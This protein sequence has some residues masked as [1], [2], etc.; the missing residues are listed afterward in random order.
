MDPTGNRPITQDIDSV[1]EDTLVFF[2]PGTYL[3]DRIW[4]IRAKKFGDVGAGYKKKKPPTGKQAAVFKSA[5]GTHAGVDYRATTALFGSFIFDQTANNSTMQLKARSE[6]FCQSRDVVWSGVIDTVGSPALDQH[7]YM[8]YLQ[9]MNEDA[10]SRAA[11]FSMVHNGIPGTKNI[12]AKSGVWV[13]SENV[14]TAQIE[15]CTVIGNATNAIY[16]G[17][18]PGN[19]Q[20]KDGFYR[21]NEVSQNRFSGKGS[22]S[23]GITIE[24]DS[25][26]Y[27]GPV[28]EYGD[29]GERIATSGIQIERGDNG[30]T[31]PSGAIIRN[32]DIR[33][34]SVGPKGM[35]AGI[36]VLGSGG[37]TK[38]GNSRIVTTISERSISSERP[39][40]GYDGYTAPPP[41][42][43]T[44][45]DS[46][47]MGTNASKA[48][49]SGVRT[50]MFGVRVSKFRVLVPKA[51]TARISEKTSGSG[52]PVKPAVSA[53]QRKSEVANHFPQYLS[54]TV[55]GAV[56]GHPIRGT[57][58]RKSLP[59]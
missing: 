13:G 46:L 51:S 57:G 5:A 9:S 24:I 20:I 56:R 47:L 14:G 1:P 33:I 35:C 18:T 39:G 26:N 38:I 19:T 48:M 37:A 52:K 42:N 53:L 7:D 50:H 6:G 15:D 45:I 2:P 27:S 58:F 31:K 43:I 32:A 25:D 28:G 34:R 22:W 40:G 3:L 10:V 8:C 17:R 12:G 30:I 23:D 29:W 59:A 4:I 16:G 36:A 21:N 41:H 49:S 55:R 44:V 54:R 11:R